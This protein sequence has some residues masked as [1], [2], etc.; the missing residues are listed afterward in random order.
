MF[1]I[2]AKTLGFLSLPSIV[3]ACARLSLALFLLADPLCALGLP[4]AGRQRPADR[5][6]SACCPSA[7][8][9]S[10]R[11]SSD[12][13]PLGSPRKET[14]DGIIVLGGTIDPSISARP[15]R[16][17]AKSVGRACHRGHRIGAP[18]SEGRASCSAAAMAI[19]SPTGSRKPIS[20]FALFVKISA[21]SKDHLVAER[22]SRDTAENARLT[23]QLVAPAPGP[24]LASGDIRPA[25]AARNRRLSRS[26]LSGGGL[27]R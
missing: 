16:G 15:R 25:H 14:P 21:F 10:I 23:K 8:S 13:P 24:T 27:T 18:V 3:L 22:Q 6:R 4:S 26:R 12:F 5:G 11:S 17:R 20:P 1:H 19:C 9:S 2:L 7:V